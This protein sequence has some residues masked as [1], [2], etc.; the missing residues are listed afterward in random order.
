MEFVKFEESETLV[1][2]QK[3]EAAKLD[4]IKDVIAS[5]GTDIASQVGERKTISI[6]RHTI[7][8]CHPSAADSDDEDWFGPSGDKEVAEELGG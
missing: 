4:K 8:Y 3:E 5:N 6:L 7:S 1:K 2:K